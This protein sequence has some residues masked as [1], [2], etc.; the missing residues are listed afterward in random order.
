[1]RGFFALLKQTIVAGAVFKTFSQVFYNIYI[2]VLLAQ[3]DMFST[4]GINCKTNLGLR[5]HLHRWIFWP[6]KIH[7]YTCRYFED[8]AWIW[9]YFDNQLFTDVARNAVP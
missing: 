7:C 6:P 1:M 8:F 9:T 3:Y 5:V 4:L 2:Y